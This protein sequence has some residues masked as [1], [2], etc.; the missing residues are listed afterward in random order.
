[1]FVL[2][3]SV[4]CEGIECRVHNSTPRDSVSDD[5]NPEISHSSG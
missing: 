1:M 5:F 4:P 2:N 3:V